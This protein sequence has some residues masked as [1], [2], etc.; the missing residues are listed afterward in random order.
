M[1]RSRHQNAGQTRIT[2][3]DNKSFE[4]VA[5]FRYLGTTAPNQNMIHEQI[6]TIIRVNS[7]NDY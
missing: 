1:V 5:K 6:K 3:I 4:D 7:G 2:N